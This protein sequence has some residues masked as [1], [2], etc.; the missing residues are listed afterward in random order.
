MMQLHGT[1]LPVLVEEQTLETEH[2][3]FCL[4]QEHILFAVREVAFQ[5]ELVNQLLLHKLL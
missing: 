3:W 1:G 2:Q 5:E 4:L